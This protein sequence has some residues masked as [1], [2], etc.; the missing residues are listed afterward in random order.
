MSCRLHNSAA[1]GKVWS[2]LKDH[3]MHPSGP[4]ALA[5]AHTDSGNRHDK[6]E[7][8][9]RSPVPAGWHV[10]TRPYALLSSFS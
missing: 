10:C 5:A 7:Q 9:K 2:R 4:A 1:I 6:T 8:D 3:E